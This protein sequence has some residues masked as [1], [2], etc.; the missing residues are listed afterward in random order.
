MTIK[1]H[2]RSCPVW[3]GEDC[4][5]TIK[6]RVSVYAHRYPVFVQCSGCGHAPYG[7]ELTILLGRMAANR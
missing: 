6:N 4:D 5:C 7:V 2:D 1:K 3:K